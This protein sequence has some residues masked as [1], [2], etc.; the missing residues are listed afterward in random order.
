MTVVADHL[1]TADVLAT[2]LFVIGAEGID[3]AVARYGCVVLAVDADG[4]LHTGGDLSPLLARADPQPAA[5]KT[6][7]VT[8]Q[9]FGSP[10]RS[11]S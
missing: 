10:S 1:G 2:S 5:Q 7:R 11:L 9:A 4:L 6:L 3:W 8:G